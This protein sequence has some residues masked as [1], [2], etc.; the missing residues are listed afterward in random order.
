MI[1][2]SPGHKIS[3]LSSVR[4]VKS[5][6]KIGELIPEPIRIADIASKDHDNTEHI[7]F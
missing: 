7:L 6:T 1:Y 2:V 4:L 3:L 5:L